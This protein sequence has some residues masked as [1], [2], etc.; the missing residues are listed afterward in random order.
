[1]LQRNPYFSPLHT[2]LP[3]DPSKWHKVWLTHTLQRRVDKRGQG[4]KA[5]RSVELE[6]ST[7]IK[8]AFL[9]YL[10]GLHSPLSGNMGKDVYNDKL[11]VATSFR[12]K[13]SVSN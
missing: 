6:G 13:R 5:W 4:A 2:T 12:R 10:M 8:P 9:F 11:Y 7:A 3:G 1:M